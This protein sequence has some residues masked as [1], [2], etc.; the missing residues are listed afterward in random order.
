MQYPLVSSR[1]TGLAVLL[2]AL[3]AWPAAW[4]QQPPASQEQT[5]PAGTVL[6]IDLVSREEVRPTTGVLVGADGLVA[7]PLAFVRE[8]AEL[9]VLDGG[10]NV[11]RNGRRASV[12]H[13][14][15]A[16]GLAILQVE[17]LRGTPLELAEPAG[18]N[19]ERLRFGAFPPAEQMAAGIG[20]MW[21]GATLVANPE[22]G[23][24]G[25]EGEQPIPNVSG[26]LFNRCLHWV[27]YSLATGEPALKSDFGPIVLFSPELRRALASAGVPVQTAYCP[28]LANAG[29]HNNEPAA[30]PPAAVDNP[31]ENDTDEGR[32]EPAEDSPALAEPAAT[33]AAEPGTD[34]R[35]GQPVA[36]TTEPAGEA[37]VASPAGNQEATAAEGQQLPVPGGWWL[38]A[39]AL[40]AAAGWWLRKRLT[41]SGPAK[42]A[43]AGASQPRHAADP[44]ASLFEPQ[45]GR[46]QLP[47]GAAGWWQLTG[48]SRDGHALRLHLPVISGADAALV[49]FEEHG[50][51]W[52]QEQ[53][54]GRPADTPGA[55]LALEPRPAG[56]VL[57]ALDSGLACNVAGVS[58]L[59]GEKVYVNPDDVIMVDGHRF[60]IRI[61]EPAPS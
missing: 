16:S 43:A 7:V 5:L 35:S 32:E 33:P 34:A 6:A 48:E 4:G 30:E 25:L 45:P 55:T 59:P 44:G 41:A 56:L 17:G 46:Q 60:S 50:L 47:G 15:P 9:V 2:G 57:T 37:T 42:V 14:I 1:L 10:G 8:G 38:L 61:L 52:Q 27:G 49:V 58:C 3:A 31:A 12:L 22:A 24:Y 51:R 21:L 26:P 28:P 18:V 19:G 20:P 36:G 39:L 13:R 40:L 53:N 54:G 11:L 23:I 29:S